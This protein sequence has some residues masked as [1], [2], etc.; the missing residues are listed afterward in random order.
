M[1][2]KNLEQFKELSSEEKIKE[3][4]PEFDAGEEF[5][6]NGGEILKWYSDGRPASWKCGRGEKN[7]IIDPKGMEK[8]A[9]HSLD[10]DGNWMGGN[11]DEELIKE[12]KRWRSDWMGY[13]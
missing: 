2:E 12:I 6:K 9:L 5:L 7:E 1:A 3:K 10:K 11:P 4:K 8:M 13:K